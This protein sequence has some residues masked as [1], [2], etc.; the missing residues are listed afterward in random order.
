MKPSVQ[1]TRYALIGV[2][3]TGIHLFIVALLIWFVGLNQ[4]Y[5]NIIAYIIASSL[6]F[7]MNAKW[8]FKRKPEARNYVRFQLVSV[9]GLIVSATLGYLGDH[10]GWHFAVT[11][12]LIALTV[13]VVSF[14]LH[15]SYTFSK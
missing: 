7:V 9:L 12:F 5:A 15:R 4:M 11:V 6:S 2:G 3:N 14:L 1:V 10:F 13:P 8:S